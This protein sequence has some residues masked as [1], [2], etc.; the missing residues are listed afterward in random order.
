M[1]PNTQRINPY[2][3][4][5]NTMKVKTIFL[6]YVKSFVSAVENGGGYLSYKLSKLR[7]KRISMALQDLLAKGSAF[8]ML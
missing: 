6:A 8:C 1:S 5:Y 4:R 3:I 7:S 2:S